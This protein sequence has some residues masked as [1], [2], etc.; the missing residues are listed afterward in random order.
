MKMPFYRWV[1]L[2]TGSSLAVIAGI[3]C[4]GDRVLLATACLARLTCARP[5]GSAA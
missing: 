5:R 4:G 2:P 1:H 3:L